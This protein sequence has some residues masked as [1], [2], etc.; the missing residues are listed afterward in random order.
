MEWN[1]W[2]GCKKI[3]PGCQNCYV[4]RRD[5]SVGRDAGVVTRTQAFDLPVRRAR[6]GGYKIPSGETVNTCFTSDFFLDAA[7]GWRDEAW[8]YIRERS[9]LRFFFITKRIDRFRDCIPPDWGDGYD[10]VAIGCTAE[11]Q[12]MADY[13]LPLFLSAP[14]KHRIIICEPLL[15]GIELE[16]HLSPDVELLIAGGESGNNAR[17][18]DYE[19]VKALRRQCVLKGVA[20]GFK[21]TGARFLKDG[22]IYRIPRKLQHSQAKKAGIDYV[23]FV[24]N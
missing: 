18:C 5:E 20:F 24:N 21:Q 3:S 1:P 14:I 17:L 8:S 4:Y 7:D 13:R 12:K 2:H 15:S 9:D 11:N 16:E 10:N 6:N 22:R 23:P 19:W